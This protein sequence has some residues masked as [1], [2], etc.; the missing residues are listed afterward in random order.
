MIGLNLNRQRVKLLL[1][2][3]V[4]ANAWKKKS[5]L[6]IAG[7]LGHYDVLCFLQYWRVLIPIPV[8]YKKTC[9]VI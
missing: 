3:Q 6:N 9:D 5:L 8:L 4:L 7:R 1:E 2:A